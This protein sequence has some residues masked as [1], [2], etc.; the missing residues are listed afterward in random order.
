LEVAVVGSI[1][2]TGS[3]GEGLGRDRTGSEGIVNDLDMVAVV[4][5]R[6]M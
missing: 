2:Y 5:T 1:R 4:L 6:E 3:D